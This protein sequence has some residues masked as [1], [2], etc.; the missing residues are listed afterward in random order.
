MAGQAENVTAPVS[1][2][3]EPRRCTA[4][5]A[6][7]GA[8]CKNPAVTGAVVCFQHG[9]KAPQV[10]QKARQRIAEAKAMETASERYLK[11]ADTMPDNPLEALRALV[12][13]MWAVNQD[14]LGRI[15]AEPERFAELLPAAIGTMAKL[16]DLVVNWAR[17]DP[18]TQPGVRTVQ[19]LLAGIDADEV[20]ERER[21]LADFD[22]M[23]AKVGPVRAAEWIRGIGEMMAGVQAILDEPIALNGHVELEATPE[24]TGPTETPE[25]ASNGHQPEPPPKPRS[26]AERRAA[27]DAAEAEALARSPWRVDPAT[28]K[29][30]A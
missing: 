15:A 1:A 16:N 24:A 3:R 21:L 9:A 30:I 25:T 5:N 11:Q 8:P 6:K 17:I 27:A 18:P 12:R 28:G 26:K 19:D 22:A 29:E 14:L 20:D 13:Q 7:T 10:R 4:H 2:P 23:A